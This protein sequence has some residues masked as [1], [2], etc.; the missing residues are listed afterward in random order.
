MFYSL[1]IMP[2]TGHIISVGDVL[3][4]LGPRLL[5]RGELHDDR[6][7]SPH[8]PP[9]YLGPLFP[10]HLPRLRPLDLAS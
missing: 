3:T 10:H 2:N 6:E 1:I 8:G 7:D 5:D 9:H 4:T